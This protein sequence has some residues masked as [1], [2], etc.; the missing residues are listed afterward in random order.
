MFHINVAVNAKV[1]LGIRSDRM[2]RQ[3][4]EYNAN[5]NLSW[6]YVILKKA[7]FSINVDNI[8]SLIES[9]AAQLTG[10]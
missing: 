5:P 9:V 1:I 7:S 3:I 6:N 10:K 4:Y 2:K 8:D